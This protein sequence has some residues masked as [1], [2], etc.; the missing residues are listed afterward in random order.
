MPRCPAIYTAFGTVMTVK[1]A[2]AG[3]FLLF[4][5][6]QTFTSAEQK[7]LSPDIGGSQLRRGGARLRGTYGDGAY[8]MHRFT[9]A[10]PELL[11]V[12]RRRAST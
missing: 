1:S 9:S 12:T 7:N 4:F 6:P 5:P 10:A 2:R 11:V 8:I 3:S